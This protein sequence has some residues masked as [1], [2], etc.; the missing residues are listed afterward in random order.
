MRENQGALPLWAVGAVLG[1][2]AAVSTL[3]PGA[4]GPGLLIGAC[5][6][7]VVL[8]RR[9]SAT[10][11]STSVLQALKLHWAEL[12][13][14]ELS[15]QAQSIRLHHGTQPVTVFLSHQ[16][17][18]TLRARIATP[19]GALPMTFRIW[20]S[21]GSRPALTPDG[22]DT[23]GLPLDRSPLVESWLAGRF[24]AESNDDE[25][26]T[27][28][29]G[30]DVTAGLL[31]VTRALGGELEALVFDGQSLTIA[32]R[33]P[34]VADPERALQLARVLWRPFVP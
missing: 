32:L 10:R 6:L 13:G 12:P 28:L 18:S 11:R 23:G 26:L 2:F 17:R 4:L 5:V 9:W 34:I 22:L 33:G 31:E 29:I 20:P 25:R 7:C 24:R 27:A 19:I 15:L 30:P 14:A 3:G 8:W 16:E 21:Q 1:A